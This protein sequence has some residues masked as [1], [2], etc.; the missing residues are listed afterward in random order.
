METSGKMKVPMD[1]QVTELRTGEKG[2]VRE[3]P[4]HL[5]RASLDSLYGVQF[6]S[7]GNA[8]T[9][10]P[11]REFALEPADVRVPSRMVRNTD[12]ES[13]S[14]NGSEDRHEISD[15]VRSLR[16]QVPS[17]ELRV[18]YS[19]DIAGSLGGASG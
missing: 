3:I 13:L 12:G 14:V 19:V 2:R 16:P 15:F 1:T 4:H 10:L 6:E 8:I 5:S 18:G 9:R 7:Q 17:T 11:R